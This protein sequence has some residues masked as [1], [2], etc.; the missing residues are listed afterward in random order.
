MSS[1]R[2]S[3]HVLETAEGVCLTAAGIT[4]ASGP[5]LRD[6]ADELVRKVLMIAMAFR[7]GCAAPSGPEVK[8]DPAIHAFIWEL[9]GF[10]ARGGDIR[11]R[12]FADR[13]SEGGQHEDR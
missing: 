1:F 9:G 7:S 4:Q 8:I 13:R 5:T 3:L 10:A 6:A 12:L 2:P 11:E